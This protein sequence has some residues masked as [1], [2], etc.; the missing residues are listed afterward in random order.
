ML[1]RLAISLIGLLLP[2][3]AASAQSW[4]INIPTWVSGLSE[5]IPSKASDKVQAT[6]LALAVYYESRG[7]SIRGQRAVASVIVNRARSGRFPD[8]ACGVV[9]QPK[10]FSFIRHQPLNPSGPSWAR[11]VDI[12]NEFADRTSSE[13]RY[14]FF[15]SERT[16]HGTR[17]GGHIFR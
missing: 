14:M 16:L 5:T 6:C 1:K 7:E 10:Q 9:F 17:I 8:T 3:T 2:V 12:G 15:S 11:A 13:N 4:N